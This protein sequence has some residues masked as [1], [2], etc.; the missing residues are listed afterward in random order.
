MAETGAGTDLAHEA[1][2]DAVEARTFVA[3]TLLSSAQSSEVLCVRSDHSKKPLFILKSKLI[4]C[5]GKMNSRKEMK[6]T[7]S[8]GDHISSQLR[9]NKRETI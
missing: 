3:E 7:S 6:L 2:D 1:G 4:T 9:R 8:L 5:R